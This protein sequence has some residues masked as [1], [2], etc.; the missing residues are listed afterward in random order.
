MAATSPRAILVRDGRTFGVT[1][2]AAGLSTGLAAALV[3]GLAATIEDNLV[4]SISVVLAN[5]LGVGVAVGLAAG[6]GISFVQAAWGSFAI[7]RCWLA[8]MRRLPWRLIGFLSDAHER[9]VM[10]QSGAV[11]QFRHAEL[12]RRLATRV[13][14]VARERTQLFPPRASI[15]FDE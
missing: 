8:L 2:I 15:P 12:Q 7:T 6:L 14:H 1:G 10:R 11:Y 3:T 5:G 4:A 13:P 9:G